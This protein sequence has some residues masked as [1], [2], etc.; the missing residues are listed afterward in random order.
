MTQCTLS[1]YDFAKIIPAD[2]LNS[3]CYIHST[4]IIPDV[5]DP[6]LTAY[7]GLHA[8]TAQEAEDHGV[9]QSFYQWVP[10]ML[11]LQVNLRKGM[12]FCIMQEK[13]CKLEESLQMNIGPVVLPTESGVV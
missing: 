8:H 11:F 2:M 6:T 10:L 7:P 13:K 9:V 5:T 4:F 1:A 12:P 3:Y